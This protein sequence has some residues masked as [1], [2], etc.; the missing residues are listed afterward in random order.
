MAA[1]TG[2]GGGAL[3]ALE[4]F[5]GEWS[6]AVAFGGAPPVDAGARVGFAWLPGGRHCLPG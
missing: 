2:S 6:M 3:A 4:P 1:A 5:V